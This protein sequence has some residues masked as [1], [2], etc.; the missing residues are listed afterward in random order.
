MVL[1]DICTFTPALLA[2]GVT[3]AQQVPAVSSVSHTS[4]YTPSPEIPTTVVN[5]PHQSVISAPLLKS[6]HSTTSQPVLTVPAPTQPVAKVSSS[7]VLVRCVAGELAV[8][9]R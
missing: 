2:A 3:A 4:V 1:T 7:L 8:G 9:R 5:I 6:L